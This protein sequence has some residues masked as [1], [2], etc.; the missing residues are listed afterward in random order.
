MDQNLLDRMGACEMKLMPKLTDEEID[1]LQAGRV[2][3]A[4]IHKHIFDFDNIDLYEGIWPENRTNQYPGTENDWV[5]DSVPHYSTDISAAW[6]V[7]EKV[8]ITWPYFIIGPHSSGGWLL[9]D[10]WSDETSQHHIL[11]DTVSLAICRAAL[12]SCQ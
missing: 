8:K 11:A 7:I 9:S 5:K 2:L 4:L 1:S 3:D 6:E 12:K 10:S